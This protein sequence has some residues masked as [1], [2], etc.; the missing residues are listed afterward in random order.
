VFNS[1]G[2]VDELST[3]PLLEIALPVT[4]SRQQVLEEDLSSALLQFRRRATQL[5]QIEDWYILNGT[6]P[7]DVAGFPDDIGPTIAVG[8]EVVQKSYRPAH[9]FLEPLVRADSLPGKGA[10]V[11]HATAAVQ[12]AGLYNRNPGALG[13][14]GGARTLDMRR[15]APSVFEPLNASPL[16]NTGLMTSIVNAVST[17][18]RNGYVA[19]YTCL[20]GR[21]PFRKAYEPGAESL[22]LPR[23]RLEPLIGRELMHASAIDVP[24]ASFTGYRPPSEEVWARRGLL[25]SL[26]GDPVDLVI[27]VEAMPEF[28]YVNSQGRYVFAVYERFALR[29]KD[30]RAIVPLSFGEPGAGR[31]RRIPGGG[32]RN[33]RQVA[34]QRRQDAGKTFAGAL[35][36]VFDS[37]LSAL[38]KALSSARTA[39]QSRRVARQGA[40]RDDTGPGVSVDEGPSL[41]DDAEPGVSDDAEPGVSDDAEPG[42]SDKEGPDEPGDARVSR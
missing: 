9:L 2:A 29:I 34:E 37:A 31:G 32:G 12:L 13:L 10:L 26:T 7:D 1:R 40:R 15:G 23:D 3:S 5:G 38:E 14:M 41:S 19:P 25:L 4:L 35:D 36:D 17:L 16:D 33:A 21:F 18:E 42:V 27:A 22:V 20:L 6:Y 39:L 11:P 28:R 8:P 30:V 24:P